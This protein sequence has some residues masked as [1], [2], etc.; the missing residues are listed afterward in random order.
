MHIQ[1]AQERSKGVGI[2]HLNRVAGP[3][4]HFEQV[5]KTVRSAVYDGLENPFGSDP[6][7]H[8]FGFWVGAVDYR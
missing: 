1:L 3:V 6:L 8:K 5:I 7:S 4:G 2:S